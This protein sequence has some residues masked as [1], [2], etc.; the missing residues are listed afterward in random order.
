M[1]R[2]GS[3]SAS[4]CAM[5]RASHSRDAELVSLMTSLASTGMATGLLIMGSRTTTAATTQLLPYPVLAGP[6]ADPSWNHDAAQTFLPRRRN[7]VSSIATMT[8]SRRA[9]AASPPAS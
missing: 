3:A 4:I 5:R 8:G 7:N 9:P 2:P 1:A 6:G